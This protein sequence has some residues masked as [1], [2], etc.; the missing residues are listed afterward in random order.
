MKNIVLMMWCL[1]LLGC[2]SQENIV[3]APGF[4]FADY[5]YVVLEK[6]AAS[7]VYGLDLQMANTF[8]ANRFHVVGDKEVENLPYEDK[9]RTLGARLT[10]DSD[11]DNIL[12]GISLQDFITGRT[13][14]SVGLAEDGKLH[15]KKARDQA[16]AQL[17]EALTAAINRDRTGQATAK[18]PPSGPGN[19]YPNRPA[20]YQPPPEPAPQDRPYILEPDF[21]E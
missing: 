19:A 9:R 8:T 13:V 12:L 14:A 17:A 2:T 6:G 16:Y 21:S 7:G 18:T 4:S 3:Y 11:D 15:K 1:W 5:R 20:P 10:V